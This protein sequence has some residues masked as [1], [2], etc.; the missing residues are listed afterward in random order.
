MRTR[1]SAKGLSKTS[2]PMKDH[3]LPGCF[4]LTQ[5]ECVYLN[6]PIRSDLVGINSSIKKMF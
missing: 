2:D 3:Y 4:G 5:A 1:P 6:L